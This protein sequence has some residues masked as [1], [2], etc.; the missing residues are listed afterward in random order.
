MQA[1]DH[2]TQ[3]VELPGPSLG[4]EVF[5][6]QFRSPFLCEMDSILRWTRQTKCL[7][8]GGLRGIRHWQVWIGWPYGEG[9]T[10]QMLPET[11]TPFPQNLYIQPT[12][13]EPYICELP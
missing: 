10:V 7:A 4:S 2:V 6:F 3:W 11:G 13:S 8:L 5:I 1:R 12:L 9:G